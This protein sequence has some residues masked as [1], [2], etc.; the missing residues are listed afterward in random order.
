MKMVA[1]ELHWVLPVPVLVWFSLTLRDYRELHWALPSKL[2]FLLFSILKE[3][4]LVDS[5][6]QQEKEQ[7]LTT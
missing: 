4:L 1:D 5:R 2:Q 6:E 3:R 7:T